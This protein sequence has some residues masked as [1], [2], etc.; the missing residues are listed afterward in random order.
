PD[1]VEP[2][3]RAALDTDA[4]GEFAAGAVGSRGVLDAF[5]FAIYFRLIQPLGSVGTTAPAYLR[6]PIGVGLGVLFLGERPSATAW[7][8]LACVAI[9]VA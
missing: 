2:R 1:P 7:I 4:V 8:G 3:G 9:G 5:A 6:V